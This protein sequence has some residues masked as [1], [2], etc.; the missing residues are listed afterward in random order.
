MKYIIPQDKI[1]KVVFK[2][3]DL[4]LK[5]LEK[6]KYKNYEGIIFVYPDEEFG[7]LGYENNGT[8]YIY[9]GLVDEISD[10]FGLS[11]FDSKSV[12]GRW[13]SNRLKL[14]VKNIRNKKEHRW[15]SLVID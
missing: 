10:T 12:I 8:L 4:N 15:Y 11:G 7:V 14:K 6:R 3:L 13:A 1:D 9:E 2:Y 5:G